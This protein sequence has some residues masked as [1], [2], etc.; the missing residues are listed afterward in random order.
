MR[1]HENEV[2]HVENMGDF[3]FS[4]CHRECLC[5][6]SSFINFFSHKKH[7]MLRLLVTWYLATKHEESE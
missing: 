1:H 6:V 5:N 4:T 7:T 2:P 3:N